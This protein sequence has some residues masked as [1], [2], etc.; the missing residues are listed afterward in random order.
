MSALTVV[1]EPETEPVL[2]NDLK[3]HLRIDDLADEDPDLGGYISA[4]R[5]H[6]E[7]AA[8]RALVTQT[9]KLSLDGWP[10]DD[11]IVLPR[12][13]LQSVTT[14]EY[15]DEGGSPTTW[16]SSNYIVD[17][18]SQPGRIVLAANVDWPSVTLYPVNPVQITYVAGYGT[19]GSVPKKYVQAIKLLAGHWHENREATL[20]GQ[21]AREIPFAVESL[22]WLDR[23]F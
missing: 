12:P 2:V 13:P 16:P 17:T 4:A 20:V 22:L 15:L 1:T 6:V 10:E 23:N 3:S 7:G 9:L 11:E 21:I 19:A 18:D 14:L 5:E 8:R